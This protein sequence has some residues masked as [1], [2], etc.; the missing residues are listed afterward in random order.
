MDKSQGE[1]QLTEQGE[2]SEKEISDLL[3]R[4]DGEPETEEELQDGEAEA[5]EQ[6]EAETE[7]ATEET[8]ES[9]DWKHQEF[10]VNGEKVSGA[11][12]AAGYMKDADYRQKT[13][14][15][16][17]LRRD[18]EQK[19][20][21]VQG[22]LSTKAERLDVLASALYKEIVGDQ[23]E[24]QSLVE[25]DPAEYLRRSHYLAQR[26]QLLQNAMAE[27]E[28]VSRQQS[29][30]E[31]RRVSEYAQ[32]EREKLK[33]ALP[34]W[35][36]SKVAESEASEIAQYL[37]GNG[38][39]PAELS[40]LYD[41]RALILARKAYLYDKRAS[42]KPDQQKQSVSIKPGTPQQNNTSQKQ[43]DSLKQRAIRTG[44]RE[45]FVSAIS[46]YL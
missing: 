36:D 26:N 3:S 38:Y 20:Q 28:A 13:A 18:A 11:E 9:T 15:A 5:Q 31:S 12:L 46:Q 39:D 33:A 45:D 6:E 16:A 24:L 4:L 41:H 42:M 43:R 8:P 17:Q 21:Y 2:P 35:R 32:S 1:S 40:E 30:I 19:I 25:S 22:E 10:E 44:N 27:R 23:A 29:E 7:E 37:L 34:E 14:H